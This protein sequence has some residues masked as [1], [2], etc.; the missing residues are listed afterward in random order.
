MVF[1]EKTQANLLEGIER[2]RTY[3]SKH[4]LSD[5]LSAAEL[6]LDGLREHPDVIVAARPAACG[7]SRK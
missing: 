1:G 2:R 5:A 7:G 4:L 6:L 3:A